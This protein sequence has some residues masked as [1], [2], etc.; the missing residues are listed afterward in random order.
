V[1]KTVKIA[2]EE[3]VKKAL[4]KAAKDLGFQSAAALVKAL[5]IAP[6]AHCRA[7]HSRIEGVKG[8]REVSLII[9]FTP[10]EKERLEERVKKLGFQS[11]GNY[12]RALLKEKSYCGEK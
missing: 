2:V 6:E 3:R 11:V 10:E 7:V 4:E 5:V 8:G 1:R 12:A 9:T